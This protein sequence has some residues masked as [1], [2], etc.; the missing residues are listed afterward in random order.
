MNNSQNL[1]LPGS[2]DKWSIEI[3]QPYGR[4]MVTVVSSPK[5]LFASPR[6]ETETA[7]DYLA[8][9]KEALKPE[10]S[11]PDVTAA[12]CFTMSATH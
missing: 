11:N 4:E 2:N 8:S 9:L 5:A 1:T 10:A 3:Q 12:Y 6:E 7:E